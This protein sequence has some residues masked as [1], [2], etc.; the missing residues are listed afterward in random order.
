MKRI[1][2]S[3]V[4]VTLV[5]PPSAATLRAQVVIS[6]LHAAPSERLLRSDDRGRTVL[7]AGPVWYDLE[8][9]A[10]GWASGPAPLGFGFTG[11]AT[12]LTAGLSGI[13]PS[14]YVRKTFTLSAGGA[15]AAALKLS[16]LYNDGFVAYLN[17]QE[18]ARARLGPKGYFVA[19]DH[20]AFSEATASSLAQNFTL[21]S[22]GGLL[23]EGENLLAVQ[24]HNHSKNAKGNLR[25]DAALE[26][27]PG[28]AGAA[29][30]V[31]RGDTWSWRAGFGEPSGGVFEPNLPPVPNSQGEPGE[32]VPFPD[33][34]PFADWIELHNSGASAVSLAGWTLTDDIAKPAQWSFPAHTVIPAGERLLVLC[35]G[36][37]ALP[38]LK[39]LH[40]SFKLGRG[41]EE[42]LLFDQSGA[43]RD[44]L[45]YPQQ[46]AFH[47]YGV[48]DS[49]ER[50][51]FSTP[52]PG[53]ANAGPSFSLKV[54]A[55]ALSPPGG[56]Y[57]GAQTVTLSSA[58]PGA[59]IL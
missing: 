5:I 40:A 9:P 20:T 21:T 28:T 24:V 17:G 26:L 13:T 19:A 25:F 42:I 53:A 12:D 3:A 39:Y 44:R 55:P 15:A 23:R 45:S 11:L 8:F 56:F 6:E 37:H 34:P 14:L 59:K 46:D 47:S 43:L 58:T 1:I 31:V 41:G 29:Q 27:D 7:G 10:A 16:V 32:V 57:T 51:Y 54:A 52:T 22:L 36:N 2:L 4:A 48:S 35:D 50:V 30:P 18:I 49:G 38:G 33:F